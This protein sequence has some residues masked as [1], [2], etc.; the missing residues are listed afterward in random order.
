MPEESATPE[1]VE[2]VDRLF[3][4]V[5]RRDFDAV[6]SF[7]AP[8]AVWEPTG[9]GSTFEGEAAI[10]DL[11]EDWI[12]SYEEYGI[13]LEET[14][15]LGNGVVFALISQGGRPAG[16]TGAVRVRGGWIF[17]YVEGMIVRLTAYLNS[18]IDEGRAA[19]ERLAA[20]RNES[21]SR[22]TLRSSS[23]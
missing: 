10:R 22:R 21:M 12:G 2:L 13:E 17:L 8:D 16:S 14:H 7:Y 23:G 20:S 5:N 19:A 9:M 6:M 1:L 3:E 18:D 4:A 11:Y 15:N